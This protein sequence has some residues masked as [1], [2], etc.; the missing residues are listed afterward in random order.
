MKFIRWACTNADDN[1]LARTIWV[2]IGMF[3]MWMMLI[4]TLLLSSCVDFEHEGQLYL[5]L[6]GKHSSNAPVSITQANSIHFEA[7]FDESAIYNLGNEDQLDINKLIGLSEG[8]E[9]HHKNS[10]RIGW[11]WSLDKQTVELLSYCY[12]NGE[13]SYTHICDVNLHERFEGT[14]SIERDCYYVR[15]NSQE[16]REK[17]LKE[18]TSGIRYLLFPYFGGNQKA[19]HN[20]TIALNLL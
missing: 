8:M 11:R 9:S 17:R 20:I 16:H 4:L 19:P 1:L 5:I 12:I 15:I 13:R 14:I 6:K 2:V 10:V 18:S 7:M 3:P